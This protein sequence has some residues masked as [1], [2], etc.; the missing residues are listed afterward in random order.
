MAIQQRF[1]K[2]E[3]WMNQSEDDWII[4]GLVNQNSNFANLLSA[5]WQY[6]N[7]NDNYLVLSVVSVLYRQ[8]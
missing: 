1:V 2:D 3:S 4:K 8:T 7:L 6:L 5:E